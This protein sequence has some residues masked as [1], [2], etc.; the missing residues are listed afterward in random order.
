MKN[1]LILCL[2]A[3]QLVVMY[4]ISTYTDL[5]ILSDGLSVV[6]DLSIF[7]ILAFK[8]KKLTHFRMYII[9]TASAILSWLVADGLWL[10]MNAFQLGDPNESG[11][12]ALI[13]LIPNLFLIA[14]VLLYFFNNRHR[15]HTY[16]LL[17][18][19]IAT[20][21]LMYIFL[22]TTL[23][24][25]SDLPALTL[26]NLIS[27]YGY[28]ITDLTI[29]LVAITVYASHRNGK[30]T[31]AL[32]L[33]M[34]GLL[35]Y[36][37]SDLYF[38]YHFIA[39]TYV[40]YSAVDYLYYISFILMAAA[41][42]YSPNIG[43]INPQDMTQNKVENLGKTRILKIMGLLI[44]LHAY[45][46][47]G[48]L[49]YLFLIVLTVLLH[50]L[51]SK[52]MQ[53]SIL[54]SILL[55]QEQNLTTNLEAIIK[56]RTA[57][58]IAANE[59][60]YQQATTDT[61]T[62]LNNRYYFKTILEQSI[63]RDEPF[64]IFY[65][66]IDRFKIINDLHGHSMGDQVMIE[67]AVRLQQLAVRD[68]IIARIIG[69]EFGII[70]YSA[71]REAI[72]EA[73]DSVFKLFQSDILIDGFRFNINL[74]IGVARYPQDAIT[75]DELMKFSSLSMYQVK[76][77][78][79]KSS[80]SIF[81]NN[82]I[83][84]TTRRNQIEWQLKRI[85]F[86]QE[87][88]LHYQPQFYGIDNSLSGIEALIRW[89]NPELGFVSPAE[90]I[91][92]AE[93]IG[94]IVQI[95]DWVFKEVHSMSLIIN[96]NRQTPIRISI[97][98]SPISFDY[99]DFFPSLSQKIYDKLV[100]PNLICLEVTEH[101]AMS[102]ASQMEEIFTTLSSMGF[103]IAIDDFGTG[104]SSLSYL[105]RFDIDQLKIAKE[106]IDHI[107]ED[108]EDRLI[109]RAI[110]LMS[111]G[112]GLQIVA[113]GVETEEQLQILKELNCDIIQG[114]VWGRPVSKEDFI[115]LYITE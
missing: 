112:L 56:N 100:D 104:Y 101:S 110:I 71:D 88:Y 50:E 42:L 27:V 113:E 98:I 102:T 23:K 80:I 4:V 7:I 64:S 39:H 43:S 89:K 41:T 109:V 24:I 19:I 105:K 54:T 34:S 38:S 6:F 37:F 28:I 22:Q 33:I 36:V 9:L 93:E 3:M 53:N 14:M 18:D 107:V 61:L 51:L 72:Q 13:Y 29:L 1:K 48:S 20:C 99:V 96:Q 78:H 75:P 66:N 46:N 31:T 12:L 108:H 68:C 45:F 5:V 15:W 58:L 87:F 74:S 21:S 17:L 32:K 62:G 92:I 55:N 65:M 63:E 114:Y 70:Y 103:E 91:P 84:S 2:L 83:A 106:L 94:S 26:E 52:S 82:L 10:I 111:Q 86:D 16:Q 11:L 30:M 44:F 81:D 85:D 8:A 25:N 59:K 60:L 77:N 115:S 47:Q 90:F 97:N 49:E 95:T 35:L 69:D 73:A 57:D 79:L 40:P 67:I 76:S